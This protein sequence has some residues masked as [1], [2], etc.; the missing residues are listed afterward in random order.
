MD[1]VND[2]FRGLM[3]ALDGIENEKQVVHSD[4]AKDGDRTCRDSVQII[5]D[6]EDDQQSPENIQGMR[7]MVKAR[8][9]VLNSSWSL[10]PTRRAAREVRFS[11]SVAM[12]TGC[13]DMVLE[14]VFTK[15]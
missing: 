4:D 15:Y 7:E 3:N 5:V 9:S 14:R 2:D 6:D 11:D 10:L 12:A 8:I 1:I 13:V